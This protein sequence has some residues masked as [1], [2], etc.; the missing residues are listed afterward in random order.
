[1]L[2]SSID[3]RYLLTVSRDDILETKPEVRLTGS[4]PRTMQKCSV[5]QDK[6]LKNNDCKDLLIYLYQ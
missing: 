5:R 2:D 1:M 6:D 3:G 4:S